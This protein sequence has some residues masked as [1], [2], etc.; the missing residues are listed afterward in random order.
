MCNVKDLGVEVLQQTD[1]THG[2]CKSTK[3]YRVTGCGGF[4]KS[5]IVATVGS[6]IYSPSCQCCQ[7]TRV[8]QHN[9]TMSCT[10]GHEYTAKFHEILDCNCAPQRC[11]AKYDVSGI[12]IETSDGAD[13]AEKR[14]IFERLGDIE[15]MDDETLQRHRRNLLNDL[16]LIHAKKKKR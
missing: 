13:T 4:C 16:A 6:G 5:E 10:S 11:S 2:T 12:N 1:L 9:V 14:S 7:P 8:K 15:Q 3:K